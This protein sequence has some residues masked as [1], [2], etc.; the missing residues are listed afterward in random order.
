MIVDFCLTLTLCLCVVCHTSVCVSVTDAY[1]GSFAE[2]QRLYD[3]SL[4]DSDN[5]WREMANENITW[6]KPFTTIKT[7]EDAVNAKWFEDGK[8]NA[9]YNCVDRHVAKRGNKTAILWESDDGKEVRSVV[10]ACGQ[11]ARYP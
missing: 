4:N 10:V 8:L 3:R 2:Y 1:I 5:F 7:G 9:C 6:S 11:L